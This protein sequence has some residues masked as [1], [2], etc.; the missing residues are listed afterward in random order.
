M[1]YSPIT[2]S[3]IVQQGGN[4]VAT[5]L[6]VGFQFPLPY[7]MHKGTPTNFVFA[8]GRDMMVNVILGFP[9]TMQ[10]RMVIDT[11]NRVAELQAFNA[12]PFP[13]DFCRALCAIAV[14]NKKKATA[15]AA[16]HVNIIEEV[17]AIVAHV[18][19]KMTATYLHEAQSTLQSILMPAKRNQSAKFHKISSNSN[20]I[21]AS[22]G[23]FIDQSSLIADADANALNLNDNMTSA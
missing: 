22:I 3:G 10:T 8:A 6:M 11:S 12:P 1:D 13:L 14:I 16:L 21:T 18:T 20:A 19:N 2:L 5:G 9:F 7:L 23:S 15:H 17:N 4:S